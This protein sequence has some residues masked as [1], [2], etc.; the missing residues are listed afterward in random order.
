MIER[1]RIANEEELRIAD[2][3]M[4]KGRRVIPDCKFGVLLA[5]ATGYY[6]T[7]PTPDNL[8]PLSFRNPQTAIC[9]LQSAIRNPQF[10]LHLPTVLVSS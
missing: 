8:L 6:W 3:G 1:F 2:C 4:K 5:F 7:I 10:P 9:N